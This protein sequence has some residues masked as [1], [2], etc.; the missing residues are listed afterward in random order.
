MLLVNSAGLFEAQG[1]QALLIKSFLSPGYV[2][3]DL[4]ANAYFPP[5]ANL[6][7]NMT[8]QPD[9]PSLFLPLP[10][11]VLL[12]LASSSS[13]ISAGLTD[14]WTTFGASPLK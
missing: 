7:Y 12:L 3:D 1:G 5:L 2:V 11:L 6:V 8:Q 13:S 10:P 14:M 9:L 4:L